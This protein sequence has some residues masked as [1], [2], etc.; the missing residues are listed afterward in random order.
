MN[1][2]EQE[3]DNASARVDLEARP[4]QNELLEKAKKSNIIVYLGTGAGKTYIAVMMIKELRRELNK[5]KKALFLVNSVPLVD[6][7]A[8]AIRRSTGFSVGSYCGA[9]GVDDWD[10]LRWY[11]ETQK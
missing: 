4:Y 11:Q 9:D 8:E 10:D 2:E 3:D 1:Q 6:Q 5:G 7:Q